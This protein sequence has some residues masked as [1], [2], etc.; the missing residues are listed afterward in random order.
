LV[1][2]YWKVGQYVVEYEQNGN[3]KAIYGKGL[4]E[5]LS[6]DLSLL[7]GKG[8]SLS[9]MKRMRQFYI[10]FPIG[11]EFPH[12]LNW[13]HWV[14]L[15]KIEDPLERSFYLHQTINE[16]EYH[17]IDSA[18]KDVAIPSFGSQKRQG[19]YF[20]VGAARSGGGVSC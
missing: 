3:E 17:R 9:N 12:Q 10:K 20:T 4:L 15:L 1:A 14:E 16:L 8:F 13:T 18:E 7:H 11:A 19:G 2:T 5:N 6:K